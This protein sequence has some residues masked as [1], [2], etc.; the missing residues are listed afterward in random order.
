MNL[1]FVTQSENNMNLTTTLQSEQHRA[2]ELKQQLEQR[3]QEL[4]EGKQQVR[5]D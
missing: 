5:Q 2:D 3:I 4:D 1:L